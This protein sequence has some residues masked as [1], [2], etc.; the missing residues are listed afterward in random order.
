MDNVEAICIAVLIGLLRGAGVALGGAKFLKR[1]RRSLP[2]VGPAIV[3][4]A[5]PC[6]RACE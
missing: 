4:D 3:Y 6:P 2:Y 1:E 5:E